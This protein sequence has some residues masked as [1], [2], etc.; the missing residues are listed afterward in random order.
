MCSNPNYIS[1]SPFLLSVVI[2]FVMRVLATKGDRGEIVINLYEN[3]HQ[4][5]MDYLVL[6]LCESDG[7]DS[8]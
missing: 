7:D 4:E 1:L 5:N 3:M 6:L 2:Y 8:S